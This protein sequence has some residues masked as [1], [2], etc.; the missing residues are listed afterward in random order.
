MSRRD[1]QG[2]RKEE[3]VCPG[4]DICCP[5]S[6]ALSVRIVGCSPGWRIGWCFLT[7]KMGGGWRPSQVFF[8]A[9]E[10]PWREGQR[11]AG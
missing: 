5:H 6:S 10:R 8:V 4:S 2:H 11:E 9:L 1:M 3:R 7:C